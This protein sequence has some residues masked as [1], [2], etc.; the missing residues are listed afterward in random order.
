MFHS[1]EART[2]PQSSFWGTRGGRFRRGCTR[3]PL[4]SAPRT[5]V[6]DRTR[7]TNAGFAPELVAALRPARPFRVRA[8]RIPS[9]AG[10]AA[11]YS[12]TRRPR[13]H[14]R[15][16]SGAHERPAPASDRGHH[17]LGTVRGLLSEHGRD[18]RVRCRE[19]FI[20]GVSGH[21]PQ[22]GRGR[23]NAGSSIHWGS[24]LGAHRG[25]FPCFFGGRLAR[26]VLRAR[27]ALMIATRVA[28]GSMMPSSS[29]RSAARKGL[30][31]S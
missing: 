8:R 7:G 18:D 15:L 26:L 20:A 29:P 3:K 30:A 1:A 2:I 21:Y 14:A 12:A 16:D 23:S 11:A 6:D 5:G 19:L 13:S 9:C 10:S 27:S 24:R 28:A 31:T 25:M 4:I 22:N 17:P